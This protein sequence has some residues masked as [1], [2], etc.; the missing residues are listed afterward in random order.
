MEYNKKA[1]IE[2]LM[3][4]GLMANC[5]H[6]LGCIGLYWVVLGCMHTHLFVVSF[7]FL[8]ISVDIYLQ[9]SY[10]EK[11]TKKINKKMEPK[12]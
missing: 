2:I 11:F 3:I 9:S 4:G 7:C 8:K 6:V 1:L 5:T 12:N 10:F